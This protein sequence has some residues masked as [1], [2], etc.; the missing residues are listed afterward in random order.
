MNDPQQLARTCA[1]VALQ[2]ITPK[3][4]I[5]VDSSDEVTKGL[6]KSIALKAGAEY[7][8]V[9]PLG[10]YAAMV[11]GLQRLLPE[12][13]VWFLNSTDIFCGRDSLML[14]QSALVSE[15]G[16]SS[17]GL[18][19]WAVGR[20]A[21]NDNGWIHF[22]RFSADGE[23][24]VRWLQAGTTGMPHSST[25]VTARELARIGTF[26][27]RW[28][29]ALDYE[30]AFEMSRRCGPPTMIDAAISYYDQSGGSGRHPLRTYLSKLQVR[31]SK[32][33]ASALRHEIFA[34]FWAILRVLIRIGSARSWVRKNGRH[35]GWSSF[36]ME[37]N[38]H[39]CERRQDDHWPQ[40][41]ELVLEQK[42]LEFFGSQK[43]P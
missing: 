2:S 33:P 23:Q 18:P 28:H 5:V 42:S 3:R 35:V 6:M 37:P 7:V 16:N 40:C 21:V 32:S 11:A 31:W 30:F 34:T 27:K 41:C 17:S 20:T 29:V 38:S 10:T 4:H 24:F 26:E 12:D 43:L 19:K 15:P 39:Y 14:A 25:I 8:W 1:S 22:L 9:E 13:Y 36:R